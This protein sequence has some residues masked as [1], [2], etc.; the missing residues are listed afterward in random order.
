VISAAEN[1][2]KFQI[3][4]FW[5]EKSVEDVVT[6][7]PMAQATLVWLMCS[8]EDTF[9]KDFGKLR[10]KTF[11]FMYLQHSTQHTQKVPWYHTIQSKGLTIEWCKF[12]CHARKNVNSSPW[13]FHLHNTITILHENLKALIRCWVMSYNL[14]INGL[15]INTSYH[16]GLSFAQWFYNL[17]LL[18]WKFHNHSLHGWK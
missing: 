14:F 2:N 16:F 9:D 8:K 1:S 7:G 10:M 5:K 13:N 4:R 3:T 17:L 6:L 11:M 18:G 15:L 12:W